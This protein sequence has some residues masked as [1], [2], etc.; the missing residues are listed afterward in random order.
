MTT[1]EIKALQDKCKWEMDT[2]DKISHKNTL[3]LLSLVETLLAREA[4]VLTE[5]RTAMIHSNPELIFKHTMNAIAIL[6][7]ENET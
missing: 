3:A 4:E 2:F 7:P 5:L 1:A 6:N